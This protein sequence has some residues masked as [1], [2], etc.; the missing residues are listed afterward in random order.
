[1]GNRHIDKINLLIERALH[2]NTNVEE[3]RTCALLA[4][5]LINQHKLVIVEGETELEPDPYMRQ[6]EKETNPNNFTDE[7]ETFNLII[8]KNNGVCVAC[9][10]KYDKGNIVARGNKTFEISHS[11]CKKWFINKN[12]N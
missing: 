3:S 6:R 4:V 1:M 2:K 9:S 5:K 7:I 8:S 10:Q 12:Q 11:S